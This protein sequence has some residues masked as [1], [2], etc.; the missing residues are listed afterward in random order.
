MSFE[1]NDNQTDRRREIR[2][3]LGGPYDPVFAAI[4]RRIEDNGLKPFRSIKLPPLESRSREALADLL[5]WKKVRANRVTLKFADLEAALRASRVG[6]GVIQTLEALGGPLVDRKAARAASKAARAQLWDGARDRVIRSG[7]PDLIE[8]LD[9]LK[10]VGLARK[11]AKRMDLSEASVLGQ[12]LDVLEHLPEMGV[13]LAV[14]AAR[15]LGDPH[16]LDP[17][18]PLGAVVLS[19]AAHLA[20]WSSTPTS[21]EG[22]QCLWL[23]VG[24]LCDTLSN[25]VLVHGLRP[26]GQGPLSRQVRENADAGQPMRLTQRQLRDTGLVLPQGADVYICENPAIVQTVADELGPRSA[27]LVCL[28]GVPSTAVMML[29]QQLHEGGAKLRFQ[30]DFDCGGLVIGNFLSRRLQIPPWRV[31]TENYE[32]LLSGIKQRKKLDKDPPEALWA[33]HLHTRMIEHG[34]ILYEEQLVETLL[35]DLRVR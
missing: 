35:S 29:L 32:R 18:E 20:G 27:P 31:T 19:G 5:A 9:N 17:G 2:A 34:A 1:E 30:V 12:A 14:L 10:R 21:A 15:V 16:A 26:L 4:R 7:H 23:D 13:S 22:R 8:W 28:G 11:A 25:D 24:V 3:A 6:M 33:P